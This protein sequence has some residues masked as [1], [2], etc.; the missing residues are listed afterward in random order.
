MSCDHEI[1]EEK[2]ICQGETQGYFSLLV[3]FQ[4]NLL[5][6]VIFIDTLILGFV[7]IK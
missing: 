3:K 4:E 2:L 6:S 5:K 1:C 7:L